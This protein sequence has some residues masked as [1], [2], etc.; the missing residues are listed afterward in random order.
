MEKLVRAISQ[1]ENM[2]EEISSNSYLSF[3]GSRMDP[4]ATIGSYEISDVD[5]LIYYGDTKI[6]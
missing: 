3:D 6:C 1:K 4:G 5:L 2:P